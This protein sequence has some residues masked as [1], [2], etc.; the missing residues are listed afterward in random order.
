M[1]FSTQPLNMDSFDSRSEELIKKLNSTLR[2]ALWRYFRPEIS[3]LEN[4]PNSPCIFV[5]NHNGAMLMPDMFIVG[6]ALYDRFGFKD[7][8]FGLAH[9]LGLKVPGLGRF[10]MRIGA[11]RGTQENGLRLLNRG[12]KVLI[13]PG[14]ELDSM[15]PRRHSN[16][17]VFGNR[18]GYIKLALKAGVP[19]VPVVASGAHETL[20]I[21][22]DGQK[23][24]RLLGL[25]RFLL[26]TWPVSL[27]IPWGLWIG[28][29]PPHFPL[30]SRIRI[31]FLRPVF[32]S[33]TGREAASNEAYVEECH[34]QVHRE[35]EQALGLLSR[36]R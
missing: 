5:G 33:Q 28:I 6:C 26:K 4:V 34:R 21:L 3:G 1:P 36:K 7:M 31:A 23:L 25:D 9:Q 24:A 29:P 30:P 22:N 12:K 32:F 8:P 2:V 20:W 19:I 16:L 11:V 13:Y 27:S 15:R 14:G 10:L 35:M 18:R 17:V